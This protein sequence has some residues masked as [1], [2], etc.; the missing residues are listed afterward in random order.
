MA[1][2]SMTD[3]PTTITAVARAGEGARAAAYAAHRAALPGAGVAWLDAVRDLAMDAFTRTGLPTRRLEDWKYVDLRALA[4][5][6]WRPSDS[7]ADAV[8]AADLP[9]PLVEGG[10]RAVLVNGRFC[11]DLSTGIVPEGVTIA[12]M[13]DVLADGGERARAAL[14]DGDWHRSGPL[15]ALNTAMAGDGVVIQVTAGAT[16]AQPLEILHWTSAAAQCVE[17]HARHAIL[18][19]D[20]AR[21]AL[22][23]RF[24]GAAGEPVFANDACHLAL[25]AGAA[26]DH[27]RLQQEPARTI[28]VAAN[29]VSLAAG[30]AYRGGYFGVGAETARIDLDARI[31]GEG[32]S[33][34]L[35]AAMLGRGRQQSDL[36]TRI[37]H[38]TRHGTS[39]QLV[40]AVADDRARAVFQ[41]AIFVEPDAQRTEARQ[42]S[43]AMLL[44]P[45]AE[46]DTKPELRI[47]ADDVQCAHGAAIGDLDSEQLFYLRAR[48]IDAATARAMLVAAFLAEAVDRAPIAEAQAM[49][50][51]MTADWLGGE[52]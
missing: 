51:A 20:G 2:E 45:T 13:R 29:Q 16:P 12:S 39:D 37:R 28:H 50:A 47:H 25:G 32:A 26:L 8:T 15:V 14:G 18:L 17:V 24:A 4:E 23:E 22:I 49:L 35:V 19:G 36:T 46:V 41:G 43:R 30:A 1:G 21:L 31:A 6:D 42:Y 40:K 38:L 3:D 7:A 48:G 5:F 10:A 11:A 34:E 9:A 44:S 33:F 52:A 27:V